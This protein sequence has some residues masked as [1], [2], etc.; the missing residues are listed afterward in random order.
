MQS[1][2]TRG[3]LTQTKTKTQPCVLFVSSPHSPCDARACSRRHVKVVETCAALS[4]PA[5]VRALCQWP[6]NVPWPRDKARPRA[7]CC[8]SMERLRE[9]CVYFRCGWA[10]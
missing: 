1:T 4:P 10:W 9:A 2:I 3:C 6:R 8:V 5:S 7:V